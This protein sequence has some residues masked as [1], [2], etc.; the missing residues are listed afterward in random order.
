MN[1]NSIYTIGHSNHSADEFIRLLALHGI[2]ALCDVRSQPYSRYNPQ[3]NKDNL[4]AEL[5]RNGIKYIFLGKE[6]GAR[7]SDPDNYRNGKVRYE[8]LASTREFHAGLERLRV[9]SGN[10]RIALMCSEKDPIN[11]HRAILVS[12]YLY[13]INN[14]ILHI[15]SNGAL[16]AHEKLE[17][18]LMDMYKIGEEDLFMGRVEK[19]RIAYEKQEDKIAYENNEQGD[20]NE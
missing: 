7:S 15:H 9:G 14:K 2:D 16:E 13:N 11:C 6:L 3:F 5:E 10:Y 1:M 8:L 20:E 17:Q 12:R 4:T 18:R 19:L